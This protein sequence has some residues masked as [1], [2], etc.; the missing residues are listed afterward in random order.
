M[1]H[2]AGVLDDGIVLRQSR[3][4]FERVLAPKL[5][6]AW[7]LH[8]ATAERP[9]D[10]FVLFSSVAALIGNAGQANYAAAN[11]FLDALAHARRAR[12]L[13]AHAINWG[14]WAEVGMAARIDIVEVGEGR[15]RPGGDGEDEGEAK[16]TR[17]HGVR[18]LVAL[19]TLSAVPPGTATC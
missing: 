6:G 12:G 11:T 2:A 14:P 3:D 18:L 15:G 17:I 9:L 5:R 19:G 1:I 8:A 7:N 4:A 13:A 16:R 10:F